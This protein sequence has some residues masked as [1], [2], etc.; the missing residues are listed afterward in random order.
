MPLLMGKFAKYLERHTHVRCLVSSPE[1]CE[2]SQ[3]ATKKSTIR[4]EVVELKEI[5]RKRAS[6]SSRSSKPIQGFSMKADL[7]V[8]RTLEKKSVS[9]ILPILFPCPGLL[10]ITNDFTIMD[11]WGGAWD[12]K[13]SER[14]T[15]ANSGMPTKM[16]SREIIL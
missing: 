3:Y 1:D 6:S 5:R 4:L 11:S 9:K 2:K 13:C 8:N 14:R 15:C 12:R 16:R 7:V 10:W